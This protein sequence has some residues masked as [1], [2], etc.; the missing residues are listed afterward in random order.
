[1]VG[2]EDVEVALLLPL[3]KTA[4]EVEIKTKELE[5]RWEGQVPY[6]LAYV[7][8]SCKYTQ[9][10]AEVNYLRANGIYQPSQVR[11]RREK[12]GLFT[13][14]VDGNAFTGHDW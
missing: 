7:D 9:N 8:S 12:T 14:A 2:Y 11:G 6:S 4:K 13:M 1:M 5:Q 3:G 10:P